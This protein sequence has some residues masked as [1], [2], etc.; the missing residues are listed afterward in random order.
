MSIASQVPAPPVLTSVIQQMRAI[1]RMRAIAS[2]ETV[3]AWLSM[4]EHAQPADPVVESARA[5]AQRDS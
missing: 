5:Q 2:T 3:E 1:C 4:L